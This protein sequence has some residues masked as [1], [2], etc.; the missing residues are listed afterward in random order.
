MS[1]KDQ[2]VYILLLESV[3]ESFSSWR[4]IG[5]LGFGFDKK[6][7]GEKEEAVWKAR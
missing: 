3:D 1:L 6:E 4:R 7:N 5:L 2:G